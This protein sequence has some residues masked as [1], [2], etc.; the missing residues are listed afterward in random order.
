MFT[1]LLL[2][3]MVQISILRC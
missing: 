2:N 3:E 1:M